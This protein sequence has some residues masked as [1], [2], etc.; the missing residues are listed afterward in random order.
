MSSK[1]LTPFRIAADLPEEERKVLEIE[2]RSLA[3]RYKCPFIEVSAKTG[4][5]INEAFRFAADVLHEF[6]TAPPPAADAPAETKKVRS[7]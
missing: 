6:L 5:N 4:R 1:F 7:I 3:Y 2:G